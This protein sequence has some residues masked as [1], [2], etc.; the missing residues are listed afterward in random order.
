[1]RAT[2]SDTHHDDPESGRERKRARPELEPTKRAPQRHS[3]TSSGGGATLQLIHL[4]IQ[5]IQWMLSV[6]PTK[7]P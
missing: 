5:M 1:M 2:Q 3:L 6:A 7:I 4:Y